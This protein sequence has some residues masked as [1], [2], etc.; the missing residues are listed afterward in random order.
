MKKA[1]TLFLTALAAAAIAAEEKP[2]NTHAQQCKLL[3][4]T[5][6]L[7]QT[8]VPRN[9]SKIESL[10]AEADKKGCTPQKPTP[11]HNHSGKSEATKK[12]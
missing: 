11:M 7:E 4:M 6:E 3:A 8:A 12:K 1:T 10:A 5:L 9:P 2:T